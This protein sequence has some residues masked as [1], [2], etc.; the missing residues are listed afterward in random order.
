MI[1]IGP[2]KQWKWMTITGWAV[3]ILVMILFF[4]DFMAEIRGVS[5][6]ENVQKTAYSKRV[7]FIVLLLNII[8]IAYSVTFFLAGISAEKYIV[9]I[10]TTA[11]Q[12]SKA[13]LIRE[14]GYTNML[15]SEDIKE[16][17]QIIDAIRNL[18][19][20][21][22]K[23]AKPL[24][25]NRLNNYNSK[26]NVLNNTNIEEINLLIEA[27]ENIGGSDVCST[28]VYFEINCKNEELKNKARKAANK[29]CGD[30]LDF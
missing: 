24:L 20:L 29:T 8:L 25:I 4:R 12:N 26:D 14:D 3:L 2:Q 7:F 11:P 5:E 21:K 22:S 17:S 15:Q 23:K 13:D 18:G 16:H 28:F 9:S 30:N 6:E 19:N 27:L 10:F 1:I